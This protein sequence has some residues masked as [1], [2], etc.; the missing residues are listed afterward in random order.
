M[1]DY[2]YLIN[3]EKQIISRAYARDFKNKLMM[4]GEYHE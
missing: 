1:K 2:S 4:K 3:D